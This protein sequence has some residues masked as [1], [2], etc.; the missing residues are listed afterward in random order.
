MTTL[1]DPDASTPRPVLRLA[2]TLNSYLQGWFAE[3]APLA[4]SKIL[5]L[6]L[7]ANTKFKV[8]NDTGGGRGI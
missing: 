2:P 4:Y 1:T 3:G 6:K 7:T 8:M 5:S